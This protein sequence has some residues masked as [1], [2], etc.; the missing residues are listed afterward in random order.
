[1]KRLVAAV[2]LLW[3]LTAS[4]LAASAKEPLRFGVLAF[5]PKAQATA[6]WQPLANYLET[7]LGRR[8]LLTVYDLPE[9]ETAVAQS[10]VDVVFTTPGHF[11]VLQNRYGLSAPIATQITEE[12]GE[13]LS[14]FS[15][16][17]FTRADASGINTLADIVHQRIA[18]TS[19]DFLGGYQMQAF[20]M[21]EAGLPLPDPD[22]L[23]VT[24]MPQDLP[25]AAVLAGRASVGFVRSGVLEALV[26]EGKLSM[27]RLKII[28]PQST[29]GFPFVRS[30]LLYPEWPVVVTPTVDAQLAR[31]LAVALL[32]LS[33]GS[34]AMRGAGIQ[35]FTTP[36]DYGTVETVLRR[37]RMP[38]F[39]GTPEFTMADL[40]S[41]YT[42]WIIALLGALFLVLFAGG[43]WLFMQNTLLRRS[44]A[45]HRQQSQ[46]VSEIIWGTDIGTW[47]WNVQ[48]GEIALN[49][50][51]AEI[52]GYTLAELEPFT[53]DTWMDMIHP[54]DADASR[55][56]VERCF[57][58]Q[59]TNYKCELRVR[60]KNGDWIWVLNR[61]RVVEWTADDRPMRM[62][63]TQADIAERKRAELQEHHRNQVLQMLAD[64][65]PLPRVL[66]AIARNVESVNPSM[67]CSI[68]VVDNEGKR[69][70]HGAAPSLPGFFRQALD[71]LAVGQGIGPS[72]MSVPAGAGVL[73]ETLA[74]L[75]AWAPFL[76][77][78]HQAG[79][80]ACW[81]QPIFSA[82]G[83]LL[84]TFSVYHHRP[85]APTATDL[86]LIEYEARLTALA[87]DR[88]LAEA[89]LQLA[90]SVFTHAR[91]GIT[92]TDAA[93]TIL[94]V[95]DTFTHI[96]GYSRE[97]ALGQNPRMLQSGRQGPEFYAAMWHDLTHKGHWHGEAWNRRK[98]GELYAEMITISAL[99]D[100]TGVTQNYVALFTDITSIKEHQKQLEHIAHYD[101]LTNLPNRVLLADRLLLAMAQCQRRAQSLAVVYLDLDGFKAVNDKH[102]HD[103]GD[104]L[105]IAVAQRMK[106]ALREGDTLAR[107]GG[108]EFVAVLVDLEHGQDCEP[109]L[110]R[111]LQAAATPVTATAAVLQVSA[112]IGVTVYP[113]DQADAD[114]LLR[115]ADQAM[116]LAKQ[117]GKNRYHLFDVDQDTAVQTQRES[118]EHIRQALERNEFVLHYHPK[119]NMKT[120]EVMGTEALI[121]WNHP[122]RGLLPPDAFLP[123]IENLPL[124]VELGE[125]VI[126]TALT[127]IAAWRATGLDMRVSVNIGA[128]QLQQGDFVLRLQD[129]LRAHPEVSASQLELEVLETSAMEDIAQVSE[130][131]RTCRAMGVHFALDDFG[132]GYSSLT[133][134]K[135]LPAEV[136]K[137]DRTFVR[138]MLNDPDD[139]SIVE[140]VIGLA[141]AFG[142]QVI[143]EGVETGIHAEL[144]L[145]LGCELAQ[146]FGIAHP[147]PAHALPAWVATWQP[148]AAWTARHARSLNPDELIVLLTELHHRYWMQSVEAFLAG[149]RST[150]PA[151]ETRDCHFSRWYAGEGQLRFG[152]HPEI[153]RLHALHERIH[154][155]GQELMALC[156]QGQ[157]GQALAQLRELRPL[158]DELVNGLSDLLKT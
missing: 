59:E 54:D 30:T 36:A 43:T 154:A 126:A 86:Q 8:V 93:G 44:R 147:M 68:L 26:R 87:I 105:L 151:V 45:Q 135:H 58:H 41:R 146:G 104:E 114:L 79:L 89:R 74:S 28:H 42:N 63:G 62:S 67:L 9:L 125:W 49:E 73:N 61:G 52:L 91:E 88:T 34:P 124:S 35:G 156:I 18:I 158:A 32:S 102:G 12:N 65:V 141:R 136:L 137:I 130:T 92:I 129:L 150:P 110:K 142:R 122:E 25:V 5:R 38:P 6:Q 64:E 46:R 123:I 144:L 13:G 128:R 37:L 71:S 100:P 75:D 112:S 118:L 115:H 70:H 17:I 148:D 80:H 29:P 139:L 2:L 116:Y 31:R 4:A 69:L 132:T 140:S 72:G 99:R 94:E 95:N 149:E 109:V 83:K 16:V 106:E 153:R 60:K 1:M 50:R 108:D 152:K 133:Y 90:A 77:A 113:Q 155:M 143:A 24:G 39:E 20:E 14:A 27:D 98:N 157:Q 51:W 3:L 101:A 97:E 111:L 134:L 7:A 21:L 127:Q 23:V 15:G 96:T 53:I 82:Q 47:E 103:A 119:V 121:R 138:D 10:A 117:M 11:I 33:G 40:W 78:A 19:T 76:D 55:E 81:S 66:D 107:I 22:R 85:C 145:A 120:G 57:T 56:R 131:M 48:T 84:G